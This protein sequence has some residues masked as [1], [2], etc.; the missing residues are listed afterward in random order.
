M[1]TIAHLRGDAYTGGDPVV[2]GMYARNARHLD[3]VLAGVR[4]GSVVPLLG[5]GFSAGSIPLWRGALLGWAREL[6]PAVEADVTGRLDAGD[7]ERAASL[8]ESEMGE[9]AFRDAFRET[10]GEG[11]LDGAFERLTPERRGIPSAFRGFVL[12]TNYDRLIE[13]AY[14]AAGAPIERVCPHTAYQYVQ[15]AGGVQGNGRLLL[16]LHGD[17]W[18]PANAVITRG[19]YDRVYGTGGEVAPLV[20]VMRRAFTGRRVLFLGCSLAGDRP[21]DVLHGC[22]DGMTHYALVELPKETDNPD[23]PL[24]PALVGPDGRQAPAYRDARLRLDALGIRPIW[25]PHGRH[26]A[27]DALLGWL[28]GEMGPLPG[29]ASARLAPI[30]ESTYGIVGREDEVSEVVASLSS[31]PSITLVTGP[32]GIGK[33]E[34][35][36]EVLRRLRDRGRDV[37]YAEAAGRE[38]AWAQCNAVAEALG[39]PKMEQREGVAAK[40]YARYLTDKLA[41]LERPVVYLDNWEDAWVASD[42]EGR[43]E[44]V[45]LLRALFETGLSILISSREVPRYV[46][47]SVSKFALR[48]LSYKESEHLFRHISDMCKGMLSFKDSKFDTLITLLDGYPLAIVIAATQTAH[49]PLWSDILSQW[50]NA[51]TH[52]KFSGH[53]SIATALRLSWDAVADTPLTHELWGIMALTPGDLLRTELD[54][55][56]DLS[57]TEPHD[58][59]DAYARLRDASLISASED[60]FLSM[61][62]PVREAFFSLASDDNVDCCLGLLTKRLVVIFEDDDNGSGVLGTDVGDAHALAFLPRALFLLD[63]SLG[64]RGLRAGAPALARA[65]DRHYQFDW[66]A[67]RP[68]LGAMLQAAREERNEE[69]VAFA[70]WKTAQCAIYQDRFDEAAPL[71]EEAE[72]LHRRVGSILGTANDLSARAELAVRLSRLDEAASLLEEAERLHRKAGDDLGTA[73]DLQARAELAMLLDR[74][75]DAGP[76]LDEAERLHRRAG[77][78]LGTANDLRARAQLAMRLD[79]LDDAGHLLEEA[80]RLHRRA[81]DGIGTA[82]DLHARARL[83]MRLDRLDEAGPLLE[84]AERLHRRAGDGL[85]AAND[86]QV[87]AELAMRLDRLDDAGY[88]LE[89]AERLHRRAGN[90]LGTANDLQDRAELAMRL[91]RHDDARPLLEEAERLHRE[92]GDGLGTANDLFARAE[93]ATLLG[94]LDGAGTLLEEAERLHREAGS[95]LGTAND[96]YFRARLAMRLGRLGEAGPLLEDAERL[97]REARDGLGI[98]NDLLLRARLLALQGGYD[99]ALSELARAEELYEG[100][101]DEYSLGLAH[102]TREWI[103]QMANEE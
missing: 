94:D 53:S 63:R 2:E 86:L 13:R 77:D 50:T 55:L 7:F 87:R 1:M 58:W 10:F 102:E 6:G 30:P 75:N 26:E 47:V 22:C 61:L 9:N 3:E 14:E 78:A 96:L 64:L 36:R 20:E 74:L 66:A 100:M 12:T 72:R 8:V 21:L 89:E 69:S 62:H 91:G 70:A 98:A 81:G 45:A 103:E 52:E 92:A 4:G 60:G 38:S 67:S 39:V 17:A 68:V 28:E 29:G 59:L 76:M 80:E 85:G 88:L 95:T 57:E 101:S 44:L 43:R 33:T 5:A 46:D 82:N 93:L 49:S 31:K 84:E 71:L 40:D 83:A 65:L 51:S 99:R 24:A 42:D 34:V 54:E 48:P 25:Y 19:D 37:V 97:H 90:A 73:S 11:V 27:L 56:A 15:A 79:R 23:D 16:K 18:D 41:S 35:C 32:G